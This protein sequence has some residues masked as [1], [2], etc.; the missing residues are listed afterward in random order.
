M[1]DT[2]FMNLKRRTGPAILPNGC[3]ILPIFFGIVPTHVRNSTNR[4]FNYS[5]KG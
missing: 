5:N 2:G 1:G 4:H 3:G